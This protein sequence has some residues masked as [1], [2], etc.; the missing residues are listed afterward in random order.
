M[1]ERFESTLPPTGFEDD[2]QRNDLDAPAAAPGDLSTDTEFAPSPDIEA[3]DDA[4][5]EAPLSSADTDIAEA[6]I[7]QSPR[8]RQ[9]AAKRR[10]TT[11]E[12]AEQTRLLEML[13]NG[14]LSLREAVELTRR[15][16]RLADLRMSRVVK[17]LPGSTPA[18]QTKLKKIGWSGLVSGQGQAAQL[19]DEHVDLL[20]RAW[21]D[22]TV[23]YRPSPGWP[24]SPD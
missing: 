12:S 13:R 6:V 20:V 21:P 15:S 19:P 16:P 17:E 7:V 10:A 11:M 23:L 1:G 14:S 3:P 5:E 4:S 2:P 24:W 18:L 9:T 22:P 8:N